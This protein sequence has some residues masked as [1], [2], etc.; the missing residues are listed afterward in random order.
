MLIVLNV[1]DFN[2]NILDTF[3][4]PYQNQCDN[5]MPLAILRSLGT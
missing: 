1:H 4:L 5:N 3:I 2:P